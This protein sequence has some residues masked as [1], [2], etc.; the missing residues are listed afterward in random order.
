MSKKQN[1]KLKE[2]D[3]IVLIYMP[4]EDVDTGTKGK[5]KGIGQQPSFGSEFDYMYNMEWYD[6]D[7]KV[8]STLS[9]LPQSDTWMLD[10]DFSQ[11]NL[12]EARFTDL[13]DLI[14]H[15]EWARLFKKSDLKYIVE[16]LELIRQ[17]GVVN[18]FQSGQFLGQTKEYLT[19]Y[20]DLYQMQR[21]L[22]ENHEE[23]IE[24]ILEMSEMVRNI[25]I[26]AAITDLEQKNK[27]ITPQSATNR[28]NRLATEVVKHFM[29]RL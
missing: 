3:R 28:V 23:L 6:D 12:Q 21:D 15:V 22:D 4:G 14:S 24:K 29:G 2:G 9:L 13:D 7:E 1:P 5:V 20:F 26:S 8:I 19:K 10:P 16:Y 25:M 18:M 11:K 27:E 17:L